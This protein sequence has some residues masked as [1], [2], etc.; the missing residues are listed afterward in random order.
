MPAARDVPGQ[1][2][3]SQIPPNSNTPC[4]QMPSH[5]SD[6]T[7]TSCCSAAGVHNSKHSTASANCVNT[8]HVPG[9]QRP[10]THQLNN[11]HV[12]NQVPNIHCC[13]S[14]SSTTYSSHTQ[15]L[16]IPVAPSFG[17]LLK[18][19]IHAEPQ[20]HLQLLLQPLGH[21]ATQLGVAAHCTT[22]PGMHPREACSSSCCCCCH[23][24]PLTHPAS[25]C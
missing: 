7:R 15:Q 8:Q 11:P 21:P 14:G 2:P 22:V 12:Y 6:A 10:S 23:C 4:T 19:R 1:C 9:L 20:R 16:R 13:R 5:P 17:P 18:S 24:S 25:H 3:T